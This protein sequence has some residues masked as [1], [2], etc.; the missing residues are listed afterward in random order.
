[1][2]KEQGGQCSWSRGRGY[3][4]RE[5]KLEEGTAGSSVLEF[6]SSLVYMCM[7]LTKERSSSFHFFRVL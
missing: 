2:E 5:L 1:M 7:H 4:I 6:V 3:D